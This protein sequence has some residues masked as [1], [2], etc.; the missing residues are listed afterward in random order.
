MTSAAEGRGLGRDARRSDLRN[1]IVAIFNFEGP[2]R[3]GVCMVVESLGCGQ[4]LPFL[5]SLLGVL[6]NLQQR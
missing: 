6:A 3:Q 4:R 2:W 5:Y 1:W